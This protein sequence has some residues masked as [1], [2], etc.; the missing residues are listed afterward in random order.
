MSRCAGI[1]IGMDVIGFSFP[2]DFSVPS[3]EFNDH[4][5]AFDQFDSSGN[6]IP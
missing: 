6:T 1:A 5:I 4:R 3:Y 2:G